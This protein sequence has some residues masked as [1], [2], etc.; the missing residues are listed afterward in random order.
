MIS[1]LW[2][3]IRSWRGSERETAAS[4][5]VVEIKRLLSDL[6]ENNNLPGIAVSVF[7]NNAVII[8]EGFGYARLEEKVAM[9]PVSTLTRAASASKPIAAM[10]LGKLVASGQMAWDESFYSYVPYFPKKSYDFSLRQLASHTAGIRAYKGKEFALNKS[11]SIR[12]GLTVFQDDPLLFKPGTSYAYT[13]FDWV[14]LSLAVEEVTGV[15][16]AE[17]VEQE[18]LRPIGLSKTR[19]EVP[20]DTHANVARFYTKN[21]SGFRKAV[22]VDNRYKLAGGGYLTTANE[23]ARFGQACL[24][25]RILDRSIMAEIWKP[26]LI[27]Q[28]NTYYGLGWEVSEDDLGRPYF[29]H[30]GN[31]VGAY[32]NFYLYP[33]QDVVFVALINCTDP[34]VQPVLDQVR[35]LILSE[36]EDVV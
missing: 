11:F 33:G 10:A 16:F 28:T 23:L 3:K 30:R 35:N 12:D 8:Q 17:F 26:Q 15:P 13:S 34:G 2:H 27:D 25:Y 19:P 32:T 7:K 21:R 20:G 24:D 29:G 1:D 4:Q 9:D 6:V 22:P 18:V 5:T 36:N 31:S 14:M